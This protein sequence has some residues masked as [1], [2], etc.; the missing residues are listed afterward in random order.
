MRATQKPW[1]AG[2]QV[3]LVRRDG[4]AEHRGR[5]EDDESGAAP[6]HRLASRLG[7]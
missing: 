6:A 2:M 3:K 5:R 7:A 1:P 4:D